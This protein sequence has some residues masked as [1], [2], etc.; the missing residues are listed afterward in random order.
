MPAT[1]TSHHTRTTSPPLSTIG[2]SQ[3]FTLSQQS[4]INIVTR[5]AVEGKAKQGYDGAGI[6]MYLKLSVPRDTVSPGSTIPLFPEENIKI[7]NSQVHPID[8]NSVPYNFSS[9]TCPLLHSAA[10]ALNLPARSSQSYMSL[11]GQPSPSTPTPGSTS[12]RASYNLHIPPLDERYTGQILVSNY[13]VSYVLPKE[14]PPRSRANGV[15]NYDIQVPVTRTPG[16][17]YRSRRG[18]VSEKNMIQ[19]MAAIDMWV[20]LLTKPPRAPFLLSIPTPRC[21]SNHI[22]LRIFAPNSNT[23]ASLHSL[24]SAEEEPGS[25]D[26]TAD[27][28]VT[29]SATT[30]HS[31]SSSYTHFA[32][33]ESSDS[34]TT[35]FPDGCGIQGTFP[36]T[37]RIRIRWAAPMKPIEG[38]GR[39]RVGVR[40]VKGEMTAVVLGK[41]PDGSGE[42]V[43]MKLEYTGTCHGVWFPGVATLLAMDIGL[44]AQGSEI[45]WVPGAEARWFVTGGRGYT[46]YDVGS[47]PHLLSRPSSLEAPDVYTSPATPSNHH[48][49]IPHHSSSSSSLLR[50][51]LPNQHVADY[52]FESAPSSAP[53]SGM[54]SSADSLIDGKSHIFSANGITPVLDTGAR[55]PLAPI[56]LHINMNEL[57]PPAKNIFTFSI[58]GIVLI[59]PRPSHFMYN[60]PSSSP[61][62]SDIEGDV[63]PVAIP[64]LRIPAADTE[65]ISVVVRNDVDGATVDVYNSTGDLRDAQTRRT[66]LQRGAAAR[67]GIEGGRVALRYLTAPPPT[68]RS[69]PSGRSRQI[70]SRAP[71]PSMVSSMSVPVRPERDGPL[72]IPWVAVTVTPLTIDGAD[73]PNAYAVRLCLPAPIDDDSEWLEFGLAQQPY[74]GSEQQEDKPDVDTKPPRVEV[75]SASVEG[76]PVRFETTVAMR[77]DQSSSLSSLAMPFQ[78]LSGNEWVSWVRVHIGRAGGSQVQ[79][80]YVVKSRH[81]RTPDSNKRKGKQKATEASRLDVCLPTFALPVGCLDVNVETAL[82]LDILSIESNL[83]HQQSNVKG[84]RLLHYSMQEY[85]YPSLTINIVA[86]KGNAT[87]SKS[88]RSL[89]QTAPAILCLILLVC[90]LSRDAELRE[91]KKSL[92]RCSSASLGSDIPQTPVTVTLTKTMVI[93]TPSHRWFRGTISTAVPTEA[94]LDHSVIPPAS[95][96]TPGNTRNEN[97]M[98]SSS[99]SALSSSH[100][101]YASRSYALIPTQYVPFRWPDEYDLHLAGRATVDAVV[102]S[103]GT[104]WQLIR[105]VYHYPLDPP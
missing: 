5:L 52:S 26:L 28:H 24:S 82:G 54:L 91:M 38:D 18:S 50:A 8:N 92:D 100:D 74:G 99:T 66:V 104:V 40:E 7:V 57:L 61:S 83:S 49:G 84:R 62:A 22:K 67:C 94:V 23:N 15:D 48:P 75:A 51:P 72:I 2:S 85:F 89:T 21:L 87:Q 80:H 9:T 34:S 65:M 10:R 93:D 53:S 76:V 33:D 44:D 95:Y 77:P 37:E 47:P 103:L 17:S 3:A 64:R 1:S 71:S 4:K 16:S 59:K 19:F 81:G 88:I 86:S 41:G 30:R 105:R 97:P 101:G 11:F 56:T 63:D 35:G 70:P 14:F 20:P 98:L 55:S 31:K 6:K 43:V 39:R 45:A 25:W 12:R 73:L 42:G 60:S 96:P 79:V 36:S 69:R 68:R 32:D 46:G 29:R 90:L 27:P 102:G 78:Q 13:Q 58:G